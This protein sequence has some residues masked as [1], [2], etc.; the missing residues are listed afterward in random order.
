MWNDFRSW[1]VI[2]QDA[3]SWFV[4][5]WLTCSSQTLLVQGSYILA[6]LG[7][8]LAFINYKLIDHRIQ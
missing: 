6:S 8:L 7:L 2:N 4:I 5:G 3:I 1:Y